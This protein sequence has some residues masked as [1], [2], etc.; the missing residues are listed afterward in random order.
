MQVNRAAR[1]VGAAGLLLAPLLA[2][3]SSEKSAPP[4]AAVVISPANA[5]TVQPDT[6][7]TVTASRGS[8]QA[9]TVRDAQ[10]NVVVGDLA[11]D[12]SSWRSRYPL[13]PGGQYAVTAAVFGADSQVQTAESAFRTDKPQTTA[14]TKILF[15]DAKETVGVGMPIKIDFDREVTNKEAVERALEVRSSKPVEGAWRWFDDKSVIFRTKENWPAHTQVRL[16]GH[17][18]GVQLAKGVYGEQNLDRAFRI[19]ERI[20]S[21]GNARTHKV[22]VRIAGKKARTMPA[23]MGKGGVRKYITTNGNHLTMEKEYMTV[24]TS[25]DAG[26]GDAG[27]YRMN[28]YWTVRISNSGEYLHSAPWSVGSQG[29]ANVSHG[30]INL[31]PENA[32]WFHK[33]SHRGDPVKI[34]GTDR[35]LEPENGWGY[36]QLN[37]KDWLKNSR[38]KAV[39]TAGLDGTA[40]AA[41]QA[42]AAA[43]VQGGAP[44][45]PA[46]ET[47]KAPASAP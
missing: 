20:E 21:V 4:E 18:A 17:L 37:W 41:A 35:E 45:T 42:E 1:R 7:V 3:C 43:S 44:A 10:G 2:S 5:G 15:P 47:S 36:W 31:S 30:C 8:L 24:M 40:H 33:I 11:A 28:V 25:P 38:A 32:K 39:T 27:Y 19:G 6:P 46:A 34:V 12:R 16:I 22:E 26:P 14:A 9:V 29:A 23:S 13:Q